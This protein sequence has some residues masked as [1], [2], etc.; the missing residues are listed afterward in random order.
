[1]FFKLSVFWVCDIIHRILQYS[2][3]LFFQGNCL[4]HRHRIIGGSYLYELLSHFLTRWF[5]VSERFWLVL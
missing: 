5:W 2:V 4:C 1:L 3:F